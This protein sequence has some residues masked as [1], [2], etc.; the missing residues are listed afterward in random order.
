MLT[1]REIARVQGFADS[2]VFM[3]SNKRQYEE[4]IT[5]FPPPVGKKLWGAIMMIVREFRSW[6]E[7]DDSSIE[8]ALRGQK[9]RREG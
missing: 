3:G 1:V 6:P 9:R 8:G 4:A 5:A 7:E 2:F